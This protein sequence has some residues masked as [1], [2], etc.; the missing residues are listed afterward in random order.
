MRRVWAFGEALIDMM[1]QYAGAPGVSAVDAFRPCPGGAPANIAV[2]VARLGGDAAFL[3]RVGADFFGDLIEDALAGYGVD[4]AHLLRSQHAPTTLAFVAH[5]ASGERR[6]SFYR[7]GAADLEFVANDFPSACFE[8]PGIFHVCSN[9]LTDEAI[10]ATTLAGLAQARAAGHI[11]SVDINYREPLWPRPSEAPAA[12]A[13]A[14]GHADVVKAS[15]EELD[16]LYGD[17]DGTELIERLFASGT[18]LVLVTDGGGPVRIHTAG[19][20]M[21]V[22][23]PA[24]TAV[25]TTAAGDAFVGAFLQAL[26]NADVTRASLP[27]WT[28]AS[29]NVT[30]AVERA[31]QAGA[32]TASRYG[33]YDALPRAEELT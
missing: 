22:T 17:A 14:L 3:G 16:A 27:D 26:A 24:I 5:D 6:F 19:G 21:T 25:D 1:P 18:S 12:I 20:T 13:E 8:T 30:T 33:A 23:P 31:T 10:R 15:T 29:G 2:A 32:L 28:A 4:T 7:H 11:V 9:T